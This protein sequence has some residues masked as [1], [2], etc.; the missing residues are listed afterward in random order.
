MTSKN[1]ACQF[2]CC[3][4]LRYQSSDEVRGI[5]KFLSSIVSVIVIV[6]QSHDTRTSIF[7]CPNEKS[8]MPLGNSKE[9]SGCIKEALLL[10]KGLKIAGNPGAYSGIVILFSLL[11]SELISALPSN[12]GKGRKIKDKNKYALLIIFLYV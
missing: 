10:G 11:R 3:K 6:D 8:I 12:L 1:A 4:V 9:S 5:F 2:F 7:L